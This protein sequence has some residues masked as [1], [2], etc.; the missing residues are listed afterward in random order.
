ME[1]NPQTGLFL[2]LSAVL[3]VYI[4]FLSLCFTIADVICTVLMGYLF[5]FSIFVWKCV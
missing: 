1:S 2:H 3:L 4:V 5:S